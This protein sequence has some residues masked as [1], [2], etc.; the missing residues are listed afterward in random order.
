MNKEEMRKIFS[1]YIDEERGE[2]GRFMDAQPTIE[3]PYQPEPLSFDLDKD[4]VPI[5]TVVATDMTLN[6][7][8]IIG[9]N[10]EN[11]DNNQ[12]YDYIACKY[13]NGVD[14]ENT[15]YYFNRDEI[16][17]YYSFGY[18]DDEQ[19]AFIEDL[20]NKIQKGTVK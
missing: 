19:K 9:Y 5:G 4:L 20:Q 2:L 16:D 3:K 12:S 1:K 11:P 15:I 8:M 14:K 6:L 7:K 13:P 17:R 18:T 10:Y